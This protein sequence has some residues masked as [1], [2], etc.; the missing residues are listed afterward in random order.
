MEEIKC[1]TF[2]NSDSVSIL[3]TKKVTVD[4]KEYVVGNTRIAYE[5]SELGRELVQKEQ[6]AE[7]VSAVMAMWGSEPTVEDSS[8]KNKISK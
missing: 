5:N 3:I 2:L 7:I 4:S 8:N 6:S 1:I